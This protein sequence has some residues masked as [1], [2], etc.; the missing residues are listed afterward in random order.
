M[1][2]PCGRQSLP[3]DN[4]SGSAILLSGGQRDR[5]KE[6]ISL[7]AFVA[8]CAGCS[9]SSDPSM[10][11]SAAA[12]S[13]AAVGTYDFEYTVSQGNCSAPP[14]KIIVLPGP[15]S[16]GCSVVASEGNA[17]SGSVQDVCYSTTGGSA[18][19]NETIAYDWSSD[20]S[21]ETATV[22]VTLTDP[23][24]SASDCSGTS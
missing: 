13:C 10:M 8:W 6:I 12:G 19:E 14:P 23:T 22:Y 18:Y 4:A 21:Q 7:L 11:S 16:P 24:N 20:G 2:E 1:F 5:V 3:I 15:L 17:C 9:D